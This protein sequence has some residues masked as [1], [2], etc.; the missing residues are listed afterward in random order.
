[1]IELTE[2]QHPA[3][4]D[5]DRL[6]RDPAAGETYVL[7][8]QNDYER[9][10]RV[11]AKADVDDSPWTAAEMDRLAEEAGEMLGRYRP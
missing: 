1:M 3:L 9:M 6:V 11:V 10:A 4:A 2:Q 7:A 8:R 5:G